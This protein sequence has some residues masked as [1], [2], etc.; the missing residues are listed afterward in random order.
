MTTV[1]IHSILPAT[2]PIRLGP[3]MLSA[4]RMN[5]CIKLPEAIYKTAASTKR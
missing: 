3:L 4:V 5:G 2:L 1:I